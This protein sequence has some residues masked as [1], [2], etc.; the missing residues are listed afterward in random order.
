MISSVCGPIRSTASAVNSGTS[1]A[2]GRGHAQTEEVAKEVVQE[3]ERRDDQRVN[4]PP[5]ESEIDQGELPKV[6]VNARLA[7]I[8]LDRAREAH[9]QCA[10]VLIKGHMLRGGLDATTLAKHGSPPAIQPMSVRTLRRN[11]LR[12]GRQ[13]KL[14]SEPARAQILT[15]LGSAIVSVYTEALGNA[16]SPMAARARSPNNSSLPICRVGQA[17]VAGAGPPTRFLVGRHR[18]LAGPTLR[19]FRKARKLFRAKSLET[20]RCSPCSPLRPSKP[21][22]PNRWFPNSVSVNLSNCELILYGRY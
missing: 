17:R 2:G 22:A 20:R 21:S 16:M 9:D 5:A 1:C 8:A 12:K 13:W 18:K 19:L 7:K 11:S 3:I 15:T 14:M 10:D 4:A 6:P